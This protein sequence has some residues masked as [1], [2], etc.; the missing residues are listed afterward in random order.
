MLERQ[1][2]ADLQSLKTDAGKKFPKLK[3][4]AERA[5]R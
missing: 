1:L 5:D 2:Q 4:A 3:D